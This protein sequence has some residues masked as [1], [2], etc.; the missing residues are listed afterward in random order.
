MEHQMQDKYLNHFSQITN[1]NE[2]KKVQQLEKKAANNF[3]ILTA[4]L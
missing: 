4:H 1:I 2:G 3:K